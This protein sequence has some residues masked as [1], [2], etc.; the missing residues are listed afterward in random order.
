[1][2]TSAMKIIESLF[3]WDG[4]IK[5]N[6]GYNLEIEIKVMDGSYHET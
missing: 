6:K 4:Q 1:M 2:R 3:R 5:R